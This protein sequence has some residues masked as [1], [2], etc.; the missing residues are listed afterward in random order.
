M[1]LNIYFV[2]VVDKKGNPLMPTKRCEKVA[3]LLKTKKA[4][5]INN[6]PF[7]IRLKY[8]TPNITQ[9]I[10]LGIDPGRENI[11]LACVN[12]KNECIFLCDI[13]TKN[14]QI[15]KNMSERK[16]HRQARKR[17][18]RIK[19]QR[20]ALRDNTTFKNGTKNILRTKKECLSKNIT[21]PGMSESITHKV[22]KGKEAKFNNR[23]NKN[24]LTPSARN[25]IQIH[26]NLVSKINKFIPITN[27]VIEYNKFDFQ[28][29]EE[30]T[31]KDTKYQEG[32]LKGHK[33][34]KELIDKEQK[35]KCLMC[36]C[37]GID[38]HHHITYRSKNGS[39]N[40]KNIVGLC[41]KCHTKVHNDSSYEE[42]LLNLKQGQTKK[43]KVSLLNTCMPYIIEELSKI[44]PLEITDGLTTKCTRDLLNLDK[45][46]YNDALCI[47][48]FNKDLDTLSLNEKNIY[49]IRHFKKKSN[50]II[51]KLN[52]REY[53]FNNKLVA[54]N[55][56]KAFNQKEDSLEEY[57]NKYLESNTLKEWNKHF[58]KLI[59]K[60]TKRT[61]T[62]HKQEIRSPFKVGD[63][64]KYKKKNK[65]KGNTKKE[66]FI[67]ENIKVSNQIVS[68]NKTKNK[69]FK[70]CSI[71]E[72]DSLVF[73]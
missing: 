43:Y 35:G 65:I 26:K 7:T 22:C 14:K 2:Y 44:L 53:S 64:I 21:Y 31:I 16:A 66:I 12:S 50:N 41:E 8:E 27:I 23:K 1:S 38:H 13:D 29:L 19:V 4:I 54:I 11:G 36:N 62:F 61:Y 5:V 9:S 34:Y 42:E 49:K 24:E 69:D 45:E 15:T 70:Y 30:K 33:N 73:V 28:K 47:A 20:K 71:L 10:T 56:H 72:S 48:I 58:S 57:K 52:K 51:H 55:R 17:H 60:P 37:D 46:H 63:K 3:Y 6:N 25:L 59:I 67:A 32:A 18:K 40:N 39:D 68:Y